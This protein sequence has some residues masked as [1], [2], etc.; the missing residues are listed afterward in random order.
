LLAFME[1]TPLKLV[2]G[3]IVTP[4]FIMPEASWCNVQV[5]ISI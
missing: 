3:I 5:E 2:G 4:S 1:G